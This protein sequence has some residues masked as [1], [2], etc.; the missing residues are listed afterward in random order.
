M[1]PVDFAL[2]LHA[3]SRR[4]VKLASFAWFAFDPQLAAHQRDQAARD[5]ESES[6]PADTAGVAIVHAE[7]FT[8]KIPLRFRWNTDP[9]VF[10]PDF[11]CFPFYLCSYGDE[12]ALGRKL[13]GV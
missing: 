12:A 7:E 13:N 10:D 2:R 5:R 9:L 1:L 3:K 6:G 11:Q 4:E 8:E